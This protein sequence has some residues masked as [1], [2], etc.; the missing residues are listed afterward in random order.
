[1][2]IIKHKYDHTSFNK[3]LEADLDQKFRVKLEGDWTSDYPYFLF[4]A[5]MSTRAV[6]RAIAREKWTKKFFR[7]LKE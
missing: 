6:A 4:E 1:M 5:D 7:S 2:Q 3:R